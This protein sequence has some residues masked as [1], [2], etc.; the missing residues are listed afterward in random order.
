MSCD[1]KIR[2]FL[3]S[4]LIGEGSIILVHSAFKNLS[5]Q[6]WKAEAFIEGV[7]AHIGGG[8]L[9]M[10]AMSWRSVNRDFPIFDELVTP[11]ITGALTE[12]FR[13]SFATARSLHP[14]HSVSGI[15][16][17]SSHILGAHH[18]DQVPVG[19]NSPHARLADADGRILLLGVEMDS[20]TLVHQA[21]GELAPE[22]YLEAEIEEYTGIRRDGS[23]I[24]LR[25]RRTKRLLRNFWQF[26]EELG[27]LGQVRYAEIDGVFSRSFSAGAM[28][29]LVMQRLTEDRLACVAKPGQRAKMM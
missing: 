15:G 10:P 13:L 18:L 4:H 29:R 3:D 23:R 5:R 7:L 6:G 14:T 2:T 19:R 21:E 1:I 20:C 28:N 16:A 11:S 24:P 8:T 22:I 27:Q 17:L 12:V 9:L 25:T 26:E